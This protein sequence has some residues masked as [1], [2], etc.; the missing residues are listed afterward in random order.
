V[1]GGFESRLARTYGLQISLALVL[2][3]VVFGFA[4][5]ALQIQALSGRCTEVLQAIEPSGIGGRRLSSGEARALLGQIMSHSYYHGLEI[6]LIAGTSRYE[7]HWS[8]PSWPTSPPLTG[9]GFPYTVRVEPRSVGPA[10]IR[11]RPVERIVGSMALLAGFT[12]ARKAFGDTEITVDPTTNTLV[13]ITARTLLV[14]LLV[15]VMCVVLS[16][17]L[18]RGMALQALRPLALLLESLEARAAGDLLSR[19]LPIERED[20]LGRVIAAY[21]EATLMTAR[22]F[23]QRDAAEAQTHRFIADAG[24]QLRTPLTV[25]RGFVGILRKGQLRHPDDAPKLLEKA[26]RQI[27]LMAALIERLTLLENWH[28]GGPPP[29][30]V[31]D[32]GALVAEVV[33]AIAAANPE[34]AV[35]ITTD[36][37]ALAKVDVEELTYAITN[38]VANALKYGYD[39]AIDVAVRTDVKNVAIVV[40]DH[41][42]GIAP[43]ELPH[44]FDRFYRGTR[45][46][47]PG[48]GLG[49]SIAKL[50]VDR[51]HGTLSAENEPGAGARF[52][53]TLPRVR[54][55]T[56]QAND[57]PSSQPTD[58]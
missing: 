25:L 53:I 45:R 52:T 14:A 8:E 27:G 19:P 57:A 55:S 39:G 4:A 16:Y 15:C 37:E 48:S 51:A 40:V 30:A 23:A 32:I 46:D 13:E 44:L 29:G 22:A 35:R 20:E 28:A 31:T 26:E 18:A 47:V 6:G 3:T 33:G 11:A 1:K 17:G 2:V 5:Y 42:T 43:E 38:L 10:L 56:T 34:R 50:A 21:N 24:H 58:T 54:S 41:G 36:G 49:L 12:P 7:G 9:K